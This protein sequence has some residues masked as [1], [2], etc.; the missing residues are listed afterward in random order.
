MLISLVLLC[1][2]LDFAQA[3]TVY[4]GQVAAAVPSDAFNAPATTAHAF[5]NT[6]LYPPAISNPA[7][8]NAFTLTLQKD[9]AVVSGLSIAHVGGCLWGFSIEMSV[10]SQV[11]KSKF[12]S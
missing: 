8:P 9:A 1:S 6:R 10:I 12:L 3:V 4:Y 5:D 2:T 7:P 11:R